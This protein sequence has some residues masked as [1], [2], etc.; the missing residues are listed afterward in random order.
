[1]SLKDEFL[2]LKTYEEYD[3][4]RDKFRSLAMDEDVAK[5]YDEIFGKCYVGGDIKN[6]L[7]EELYKTPPGKGKRIIGR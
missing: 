4:V 3:A 2:K 1:M 6:G 5:H 7:I